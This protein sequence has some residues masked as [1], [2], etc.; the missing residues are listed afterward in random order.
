[1][2]HI[3]AVAWV[4]LREVI[5]SAGFRAYFPA[6]LLLGALAPRLAAGNDFLGRLQLAVSYGLGLPAILIGVATLVF[7][8][9]SLSREIDRRTIHLVTTKPIR[10]CMVLAG[11]LCGVLLVDIALLLSVVLVFLLNVWSIQRGDHTPEQRQLVNDRFFVCRTGTFPELLDVDEPL[12]KELIERRLTERRP[13]ELTSIEEITARARRTQQT[14]IVAPGEEE[15]LT[16]T[17]LSPSEDPDERVQLRL[18][19]FLSPPMEK[20]DVDTRWTF[21]DASG[22]GTSVGES[23]VHRLRVT[24]SVLHLMEA[25]ASLVS[26]N[27]RLTVR[28]RNSDTEG[29]RVNLVVYPESVEVLHVYGSLGASLARAMVLLLGQ[30]AFLAALG[31]LCSALFTLPTANLLGF[32]I[33]IIG[34]LSGYLGESLE[35]IH[36]R[37]GSQS[38]VEQLGAL[39]VRAGEGLLWVLPDLA[40]ESPLPRLID[41]RAIEVSAMFSS[42]AWTIGVRAG[43]IFLLASWFWGR[44]EL[45][46]SQT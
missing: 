13:G 10:P 4:F 41:G 31:L 30:F 20:V 25:P 33:F 3:W 42:I 1:M 45:G 34:T 40:G 7:T 23:L 46:G 21:V 28:L 14:R 29:A 16:F 44:R 19:L 22:P 27:G 38:F 36:F 6:L 32:F 8:T 24:Q 12:L 39:L 17:G 5:R 9:S 35:M 2:K 11:K 26:R 43:L 18:R 15:V 37:P